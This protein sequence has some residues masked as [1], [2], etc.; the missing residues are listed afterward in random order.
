LTKGI[1]ETK[2][3]NYKRQILN[4]DN[5]MKTTWNIIKSEIGRKVKNKVIHKLNIDGNTINNYRVTS[6]AFSN[7]L[8]VAEKITVNKINDNPVANKNSSDPT[9]Y[10]SHTL[11][12]PFTNIK[13]NHTTTKQMDKIMK[14]LKT[15]SS[16]GY[17]EISTKILVLKISS[18][19]I[20]SPSHHVCNKPSSLGI[21]PSVSNYSVIKA[22]FKK[23]IEKIK[24][25]YR[26]AGILTFINFIFKGFQKGYLCKTSSASK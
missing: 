22:L 9:C 17:D 21:F 18:P 23:M 24:A 13:F 3:A 12:S 10:W 11:S 15:V 7:F 14:S 16:Y 2:I 26:P 25:Q 8:S 1:K 19:F 20:S 4:S 5:V 6:D